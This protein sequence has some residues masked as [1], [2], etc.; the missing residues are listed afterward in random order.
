MNGNPWASIR[1]SKV[2]FLCSFKG[3]RHKFIQVILLNGHLWVNYLQISKIILMK[4]SSSSLSIGIIMLVIQ[5]IS[6]F[7]GCLHQKL[8]G[9]KCY[10]NFMREFPFGLLR[11][12]ASMVKTFMVKTFLKYLEIL[13]FLFVFKSQALRNWLGV[14]CT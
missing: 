14:L 9:L 11:F 2:A 3:N 4:L 1:F 5:L 6:R 7:P 8:L 12:K 13:G 10:I